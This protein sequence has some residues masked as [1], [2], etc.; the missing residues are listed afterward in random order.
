M[1]S[2]IAPRLGRLPVRNADV[3]AYSWADRLKRIGYWFVH[4]GFVPSDRKGY[5]PD[6]RENLSGPPYA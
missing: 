4:R 3:S 6:V 5:G 2:D 1:E